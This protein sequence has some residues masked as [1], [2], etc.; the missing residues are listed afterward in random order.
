MLWVVVWV[1]DCVICDN[2]PK[3]RSE[4][5][6]YLSQTFPVED[7]GDL[8]WILHVRIQRDRK[9]RKLSMY[10]DLYVKDLLSKFGGLVEGLTRRFDSPCDASIHFSSDQ[11]PEYGSVECAQM[12]A[13]RKDY[14]CV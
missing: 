11:C 13:H 14:I 10:Q 7:K 8:N 12:D 5:V 3:L 2:N 4:F 6:A 1:D 9:S